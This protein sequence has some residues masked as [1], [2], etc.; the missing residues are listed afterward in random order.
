MV[1]IDDVNYLF[2]PTSYDDPD[3]QHQF[4]KQKLHATRFLL[5]DKLNKFVT[6]KESIEFGAVVSA[7]TRTID[8]SLLQEG[9]LH[10]DHH[11]PTFATKGITSETTANYDRDEL[12]LCIDHYRASGLFMQKGQLLFLA[13]FL[14]AAF[15]NPLLIVFFL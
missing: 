8:N 7:A 14:P 3:D 11:L 12:K 9:T 2:G 13:Y 6:K 5:L 4:K 15:A 10:L 1:A